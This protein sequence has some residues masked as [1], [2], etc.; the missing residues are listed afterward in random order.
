MRSTGS[1]IISVRSII[2]LWHI[3]YHEAMKRLHRS[4]VTTKGLTWP[5]PG[6]LG[7]ELLRGGGGSWLIPT[8]K[9]QILYLSVKRRSISVSKY[10]KMSN[11]NSCL[12]KV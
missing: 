1:V 10:N 3:L 4:G 5:K 2:N 8:S 9:I 12:Y 6:A 11:Y 7:K